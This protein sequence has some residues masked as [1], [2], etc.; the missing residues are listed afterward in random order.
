M[1][2]IGKGIGCGALVA[3]MM[4]WCEPTLQAQNS[5][6][7]AEEARAQ[8]YHTYQRYPSAGNAPTYGVK[9]YDLKPRHGYWSHLPGRES[10]YTRASV[11]S[12]WFHRPYPYHLDYYR[13]RFGG[14]PGPLPGDFYGVPTHAGPYAYPPGGYGTGVFG[15]LGAGIWHW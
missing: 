7:P 13:L 5:E 14:G 3:A 9:P 15:S 11:N 8:E 12:T 6:A 10:S 2:Q 4:A 1:T